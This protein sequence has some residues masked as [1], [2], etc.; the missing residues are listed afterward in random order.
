MPK[1]KLRFTFILLIQVLIVLSSF[2][3]SFALRFDFAIEGKYWAR[4]LVLAPVLL[5]IKLIVFWRF[6]LF[7][8]WWRYVSMPDLFLILKANI[9]A[10]LLFVLY[11]VVVYRLE[12]VPRSVLIMDWAICFMLM[13]GVRFV[14]RAFREQ[15]LPMLSFGGE[16]GTRTLIIGA[17]DAGQ[18]IAREVR[19]NSRLH[20][21]LVGFVDDDPQKQK[22]S[23]Q[24]L[25]VLGTSEDLPEIV[26]KKNIEEVI[27]AIPSASGQQIRSI[28][29]RC[30]SIEISFKILPGVGE[31][32]DGSVSVQQLRN[33]SLEDLLG[34]QPIVLDEAEISSYLHKKRVLITGAGGSIGSEICRQVVKFKPEKLILFESAETPLFLIENELV[35]AHP[36]AAV[37]PI[38]GDV[39]NPSRI[40][41][42]FDE[43]MP[44]V[45]FHAAAYKHVPMMENNPAEAVNNN[46]RGSKLLADAADSFGV[47][48]FV[49]VSTDKAV[50]PTNVMGASKRAAELYVQSLAQQS[51]TRFVT[52]RFG[53]VLGSNG[54]VIPT[55]KEQIKSGGPVTVTHP[56]VTRYFM[57]IPE[58]TQLVLQAGSM[59]QGGEIYLFDMGEPVKI[60]DLAEELIRLSG[61]QPH[62]DIEIVYTGLRPG[63][64]LY[65]ELLLAE[66]GALPTHHEK[67]CVAS[68]VAP[69][70]E[71]L[72]TELDKLFAA[73]KALDLPEVKKQL[74]VI[75][76]EYTPVEHKQTAKVIPHPA[77]VVHE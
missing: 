31:L 50:R 73:A 9:I 48:T 40:N 18:M 51:K 26:L 25:S 65:E 68:S 59:G 33:V 2:Y 77:T 10:S 37:I 19:S 63:E 60:V 17:G 43:Q 7:R 76:P 45:V 20:L 54:S 12:H 4:G 74:R 42:I 62:E 29:E 32:I 22:G 11:A 67:I 47:E 71:V 30:H 13:G 27:I 72:I 52:T 1:H 3:L 69:T 61:F 15:Y 44:Q 23:F 58:A 6:S 36:E 8:G 57:T 5:A 49:M 38:I 53:N 70:R 41:V 28:V 35:E 66:E 21:Q 75:V 39:R 64:K 34:R 24:G 46:V 56:E 16:K 14:T 55:F